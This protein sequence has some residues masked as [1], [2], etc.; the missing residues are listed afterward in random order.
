MLCDAAPCHSLHKVYLVFLSELLVQ[1]RAHDLVTCYRGGGEMVLHKQ[2][3]RMKDCVLF[4][5]SAEQQHVSDRCNCCSK[6]GDEA[7]PSG[8]CAG[9]N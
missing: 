9:K 7:I 3:Y 4:K 8:S 2:A 5:P 6:P 1:V